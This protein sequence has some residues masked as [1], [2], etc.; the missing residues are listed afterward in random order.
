MVASWG[1]GLIWGA[2][3]P[4]LVCCLIGGLLWW[5]RRQTHGPQVHDLSP[6]HLALLGGGSSRAAAASLAAL[7]VAGAVRG[8]TGSTGERCAG[9][10]RRTPSP[11]TWTS[12][13]TAL[14]AGAHSPR[15]M[16]VDPRVRRLLGTE[17]WALVDACLL[18]DTPERRRFRE[19][20]IPLFTVAALGLVL[21]S[22][23][24]ATAAA[25]TGAAG[26]LFL[27]VDPPPARSRAL[28]ARARAEAAFLAPPHVPGLV[29]PLYTGPTGPYEWTSSHNSDAWFG[30]GSGVDS[31]G[32]S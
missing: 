20:T 7:R 29:G 30:G 27:R 26:A 22:F 2:A 15:S 14:P 3:Y 31:G 16:P 23:D 6:L 32:G 4:G 19:A 17:G 18:L 5:R 10:G 12:P 28:L 1:M 11:R 21:F 24:A 25:A 9:T 13:C 8:L